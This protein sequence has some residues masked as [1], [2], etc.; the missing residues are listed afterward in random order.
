M[1]HLLEVENLKVHFQSQNGTVNAVNDMSFH[2]DE[3]EIVGLVGESGCGKTMSQLAVMQLVPESGKTSGNVLFEDHDL[4]TFPLRS[5]AMCAIRGQKIAMIFQ[6]PAASLNPVLAIGTQIM[7]MLEVH[8]R[9][10]RRQAKNH[11]VELLIRVGIRNA[12]KRLNDYPHQFSGGMLQRVMIAIA[13]SC[14]PRI[15]IADE[16]TSSLDAPIQAQILELLKELVE[17]SNTAMIMVSHDLDLVA[18]YT[19]RVYVMYAGQIIE[20]GKCCDVFDTPHHPYT[21]GLLDCV[22][23]VKNKKQNNIKIIKDAASAGNQE[24]CAF[25]SR[26]GSRSKKC[27]TS[28]MPPLIPVKN[29]HH[30]RCSG[31]L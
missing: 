31:W 23:G 29:Q 7:E 5:K 18:R 11:A 22:S 24:N 13:M 9:M 2:L 28:K 20:S 1:P 15:L 3:G 21:I 27:F 6:E 16:P 4:L 25:L 10:N 26:C 12:E 19:Q 8:L 30:V 14:K 17:Q